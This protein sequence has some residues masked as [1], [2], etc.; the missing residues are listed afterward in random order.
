MHFPAV[1]KARESLLGLDAQRRL[2][3]LVRRQDAQNV[4]GGDDVVA[5]AVRSHVVHE[6]HRSRHSFSFIRLRRSHVLIVFSGMPNRCAS[7]A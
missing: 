6:A 2:A 4:F 7:S 3:P 1:D 5:S